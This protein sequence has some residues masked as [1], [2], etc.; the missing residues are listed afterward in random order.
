MPLEINAQ[1]T[2]FV[3]FAQQQPNARNSNA[4]ARA[5]A[6]SPLGGRTISAAE[7]AEGD[8]VR[9][10]LWRSKGNKN[11]NDAVRELF[12]QSIR[13]LFGGEERIPQSVRDA[14]RLKDYGDGKPLTARRIIAVK[15]AVDEVLARVAPALA[16][17]KLNAAPLYQPVDGAPLP[18]ERREAVDSLLDALVR[19][20]ATDPDALEIAVANAP[21]FAR[22]SNATLRSA[23]EVQA[24]GRNL[25]A[26][27]AEL[28]ALAKGD[29]DLFE[30]GKTFLL[31]MN[32]TDIPEGF[33]RGLVEASRRARIG[34]TKGLSASSS[35]KAVHRAVCEFSDGVKAIMDAVAAEDRFAGAEEK[36]AARNFA[37]ALILHRFGARE[38]RN[39]VE[40]MGTVQAGTLNALYAQVGVE[41]FDKTGHSPGLV[42]HTAAQ[43]VRLSDMMDSLN[44]AA[45]VRLG[46]PLADMSTVRDVDQPDYRTIEGNRILDSLLERGRAAAADHRARFARNAVAG[47]GPVADK[48]RGVY[49]DFGPPEAFNLE[50]QLATMRNGIVRSMLNGSL[51]EECKSLAGPNPGDA[52]QFGKDIDRDLVVKLPGGQQLE[53]DFE[54]ARDA[55][56]S[57]VT[58]GAKP[59]YAALDD[60]EK[61]KV[62]VLMALLNQKSTTALQSGEALALAPRHDGAKLRYSGPVATEY[63]IAIAPDGTLSVSCKMTLSH[64]NSITIVNDEG[65]DDEMTGLDPATRAEM[66]FTLTVKADE[67]DRLASLDYSACDLGAIDR[68]ILDPNVEN[69]HG[70]YGEALGEP[71]AFRTD[72]SKV[73]CTSRY[74]ITVA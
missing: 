68:M 5:G 64:L 61:G 20:T 18:A 11:K 15:A 55:L 32:G 13:D 56:A 57:F 48:L 39:V 10:L 7:N 71:F 46:I 28:R 22:R 16:Q 45:Q 8:A 51:G 12:R 6:E 14:M 25:L 70:K 62:R 23:A 42:Q 9:P 37:A 65:D 2:M 59:N 24:K 19:T 17:A 41:N 60:P 58:N 67:F 26:A 66:E 34:A 40:A 69:P 72:N 1:Y 74:K 73:V 33:V 36:R 49:A 53:N 3:Q 50:L 43:A 52:S 47:E 21:R 4:I 29:R 30:L 38:A 35:G 63:S 31:E 27:V 44:L 54:R